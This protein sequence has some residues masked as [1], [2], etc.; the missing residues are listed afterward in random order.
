M[1]ELGGNISGHNIRTRG[2]NLPKLDEGWPEIFERQSQPDRTRIGERSEK[3][4]AAD[5]RANKAS[6]QKFIKAKS[7]N[8]RE[9]FYEAK[10][11]HV[12]DFTF[13]FGWEFI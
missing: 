10:K 12:R 6:W 9:D 11:T 13:D 3:E 8:N 7:D 4:C 2:E 1:R 5:R